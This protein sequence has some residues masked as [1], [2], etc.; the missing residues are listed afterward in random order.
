MS[1]I[2]G[3]C[4]TCM[5]NVTCHE[6]SNEDGADATI[7]VK[8]AVAVNPYDVACDEHDFYGRCEGSGQCPQAA[9]IDD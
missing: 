7:P 4:C 9:W 5:T 3:T 1:I 8:G 2:K 6:I